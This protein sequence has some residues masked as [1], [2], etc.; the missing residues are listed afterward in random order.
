VRTLATAAVVAT[1]LALAPSAIAAHHNGHH[2]HHGGGSAIDQYQEDL[3]G[4]GGNKPTQGI[5]PGGGHN[6]PPG[7]ASAL[8]SKGQA[9]AVAAALAAATA[10][11]GHNRG[12][13]KGSTGGSGAGSSVG[14]LF[15]GSGSGGMG[16]LFPILLAGIALASGLAFA[17]RRRASRAGPDQV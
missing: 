15:G 11:R 4:P 3:P 14:R 5:G 16:A 12:G 8:Q 10:P 7:T 9:G 17:A 2:R 13:G 6:L 1:A